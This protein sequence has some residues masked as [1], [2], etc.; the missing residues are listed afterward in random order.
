MQ[1]SKDLSKLTAS[2]D[3]SEIVFLAVSHGHTRAG[4]EGLSS[5]HCQNYHYQQRPW[6]VPAEGSAF[7]GS[8]DINVQQSE[9]IG[10][11]IIPTLQME[12]LR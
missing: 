3:D 4:N 1:H 12:R 7:C 9:K 11:I 6:K 8:S 5:V 2:K 10:N